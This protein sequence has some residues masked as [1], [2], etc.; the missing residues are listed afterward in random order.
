[1]SYPNSMR[2]SDW[3]KNLLCNVI[4]T[5][6]GQLPN[7]NVQALDLLLSSMFDTGWFFLSVYY[8]VSRAKKTTCPI[9]KVDF[10]YTCPNTERK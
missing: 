8:T 5:N 9:G 7:F 6:P 2:C 3:L 4:D 10:F 1:M